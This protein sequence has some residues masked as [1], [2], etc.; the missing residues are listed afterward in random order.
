MACIQ[1]NC[2][3]QG[4]HDALQVDT[5]SSVAVRIARR[6]LYVLLRAPGPIKSLQTLHAERTMDGQQ[7]CQQSAMAHGS[8]CPYLQDECTTASVIIN[9]FDGGSLAL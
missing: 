3:L 7:A 8:G 4:L 2:S 5:W 9:L 6:R 1:V